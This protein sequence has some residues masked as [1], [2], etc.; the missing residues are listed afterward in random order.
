MIDQNYVKAMELFFRSMELGNEQL[1]HTIEFHEKEIAVNGKLLEI[2]KE[3]LAANKKRL[4]QDRQRFNEYLEA[5][6]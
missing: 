3:E 1:S 6:K 4:S 5:N 2:N